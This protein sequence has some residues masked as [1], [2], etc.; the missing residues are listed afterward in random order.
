MKDLS[1][2]LTR[3]NNA[4]NDIKND[5]FQKY[6]TF[7]NLIQNWS[8]LKLCFNGLCSEA[9]FEI[10]QIEVV[11]EVARNDSNF[12]VEKYQFQF[13]MDQVMNSVN[14][15]IKFP[16][17]ILINVQAKTVEPLFLNN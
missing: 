9:L 3:E 1:I 13:P 12:S 5:I 8:K 17:K 16:N 15:I 11:R 4:N 7:S 6:K 2:E 14:S 10:K